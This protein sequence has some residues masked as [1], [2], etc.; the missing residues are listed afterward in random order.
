MDI[1]LIPQHH[2]RLTEGHPYSGI[3]RCHFSEALSHCITHKQTRLL[4]DA[5]AMSPGKFLKTRLITNVPAF[6]LISCGTQGYNIV[7]VAAN[8]RLYIIDDEDDNPAE[9]DEKTTQLL[10]NRGIWPI[11]S[12][13][14]ALTQAINAGV[15]AKKRPNLPLDH[16]SNFIES[17]DCLARCS[18]PNTQN[19]RH[20]TF[21]E[22]V[23]TSTLCRLLLSHQAQFKRYV[24]EGIYYSGRHPGDATPQPYESVSCAYCYKNTDFN[25]D[26]L[27]SFLDRQM[28][29]L[30]VWQEAEYFLGKKYLHATGCHY[31]NYLGEPLVQ[32]KSTQGTVLDTRMYF[33]ATT[34]Q[35]TKPASSCIYTRVCI[36]NGENRQPPLIIP[37]DELME[38]IHN[39]RLSR[40]G[41]KLTTAI[42]TLSMTLGLCNQRLKQSTE[43]YQRL[44]YTS[45]LHRAVQVY[46]SLLTKLPTPLTERQHAAFTL[47]D[48]A[49]HK[50][51]LLYSLYQQLIKLLKSFNNQPV[52]FQ[53]QNLLSTEKDRTNETLTLHFILQAQI[54]QLAAVH[55]RTVADINRRAK[56][57]LLSGSCTLD[58]ATLPTLFPFEWLWEDDPRYRQVFEAANDVLALLDEL[59]LLDNE[60]YLAALPA[61]MSD[62]V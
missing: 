15:T 43:E 10:I 39:Q 49:E 51:A 37:H 24:T 47:L 52:R 18:L 20:K 28:N 6:F 53:G 38:I 62:V 33:V 19:E 61:T 36:I 25:A 42:N 26:H 31:R 29:L 12:H 57:P 13:C 1:R 45:K 55:R 9:L 35:P 32:V 44:Y 40:V 23:I 56:L 21:T 17:H 5:G 27:T 41:D 34:L 14:R 30:N 60:K 50:F 58:I 16:P 48:D 3:P 4:L 46:K 7:P 11:H 8:E 2:R 22:N 59:Y 54:H